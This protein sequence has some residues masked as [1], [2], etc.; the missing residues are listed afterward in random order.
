MDTEG[1]RKE[2]GLDSNYDIIINSQ[3]GYPKTSEK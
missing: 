1:L 3:I 2:L